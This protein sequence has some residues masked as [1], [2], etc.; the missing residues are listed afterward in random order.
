MP[1]SAYVLDKFVAPEMSKFTEADIRDMSN[2]D[3]EQEHWLANFIL[4]NVL[5]ATFHTPQRQQF[6][7]F[8]RRSHSA[9]RAY[10]DAREATL[11]HLANPDGFL[12]YIEAIGHWESFLGY[13]WQAYCFVGQGK[14]RWFEKNDGSVHQ[15]L[16]ALHH[17][18]KHAD[19]AIEHGHYIEDSPLCVWLTND[20][21]KS[22]ETTL[23][24]VE[25]AEILEDLARA[26]STV[27]DPL[28]LRNRLAEA[29]SAS[30]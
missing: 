30:E 5:R 28:A 18:A 4:N 1:F 22:T 9:F 17:R 8:L 10:A 25:C 2:T 23:S 12:A 6:Y 3:K 27:Q 20:G 16:Y 7:N 11:Q 14:T 29:D 21:L 24:F 26:A 15:R 13:C 19:L